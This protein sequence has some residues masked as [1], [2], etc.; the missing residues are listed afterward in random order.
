MTRYFLKRDNKGKIRLVQLNLEPKNNENTEFVIT[1]E[2]GLL[3]GKKTPRPVITITVGK[4]KRT[5]K[6]QALLQYNS[7]CSDY[8]DKGYKESS[9]L[10]I[11]DISNIADVNEKVPKNL[12]DAKGNSKPMLAKSS[13][14]VKDDVFQKD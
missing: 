3:E 11:D 6:E 12:T 4:V 9:D 13:D 7:I 1:G 10:Q 5:V 8:L 14:G 2:T